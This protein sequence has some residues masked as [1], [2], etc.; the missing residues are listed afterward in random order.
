MYPWFWYKWSHT[1]ADYIPNDNAEI[2]HSW[3]EVDTFANGVEDDSHVPHVFA[4]GTWRQLSGQLQYSGSA[5]R[6]D[7]KLKKRTTDPDTFV[8]VDD[9]QILY[10]NNYM[11]QSGKKV[12]YSLALQRSTRR[13]TERFN[14]VG[15]PKQSS[16]DTGRCVEVRDMPKTP[17]PPELTQDQQDEQQA[18]K[19]KSEYCASPTR[20]SS[21]DGYCMS[22]YIYVDEYEAAKKKTAKKNS[23]AG[24]PN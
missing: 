12:Q 7:A 23:N 14:V 6:W 22:T 24:K 10:S 21:D 19:D 5:N 17:D 2:A 16:E 8:S 1:L 20:S 15:D 18:L 13:F 9:T 3:F 4:E 11:S